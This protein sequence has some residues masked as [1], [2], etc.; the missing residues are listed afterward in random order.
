MDKISMMAITLAMAGCASVPSTRDIPAVTDFD[1]TRYMGAWHEI[2]RLPQW[3]EDGM[4]GVT[5]VYA[6]DGETLRITNFGVRDGKLKF[7]TAVGHFA[8]EKDVGEFRISFFRPFYGDYRI[9]WL[10]PGYDLAMVTSSD[11]SSL[12][13][14]ARDRN[15]TAERRNALIKLAHDWNFDTAALEF[16]K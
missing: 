4:S 9:I 13:I 7:S 3:Y 6:L 8:G 1:A 12:W 15:L 2:A 10:S 16:A 5:A 11:R 14:L